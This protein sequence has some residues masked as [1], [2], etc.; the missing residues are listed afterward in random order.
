[1][2]IIEISRLPSKK[3]MWQTLTLRETGLT[4]GPTQWDSE[5]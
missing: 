3:L 2:K 4:L 1:M 5:L